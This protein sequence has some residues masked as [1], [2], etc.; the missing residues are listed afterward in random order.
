[1]QHDVLVCLLAGL[2]LHLDNLKIYNRDA[3]ASGPGYS[4][5]VL[6]APTAKIGQSCLIGPD[7]SIGDGCEIGDGVRLSSCVIMKGVRIKDHSK[8][9]PVLLSVLCSRVYR[10]T[11]VF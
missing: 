8:V 5:N 10:A 4:G 11:H 9:R 7:V 6:V 2:T 1:M 3:L